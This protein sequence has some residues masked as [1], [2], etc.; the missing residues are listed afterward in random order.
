VYIYAFQCKKEHGSIQV[1]Q[2]LNKD[3]QGYTGA[4]QETTRRELTGHKDHM[5]MRRVWHTPRRSIHCPGPQLKGCTKYV[6]HS[7]I[8]VHMHVCL[9]LYRKTDRSLKRTQERS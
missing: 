2:V 5:T 1:L 7:T 3:P 4:I 6:I 8:Y 9:Y